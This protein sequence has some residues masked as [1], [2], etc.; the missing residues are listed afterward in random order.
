MFKRADYCIINRTFYPQ[1]KTIGEGLLILSEKLS[2]ENMKVIMIS[3]SRNLKKHLK[4]DERGDRVIFRP[5]FK[6]DTSSSTIFTR[7]LSSVFFGLWV[8]V[9]LTWY[10]PRKLYVS[11]DPPIVIPFI[12]ALSSKLFSISYVYHYQDIHPEITN[13]IK[14]LPNFIFNT[15]KKLD[16]F[17]QRNATKLITINSQMRNYLECRSQ[18]DQQIVCISNP[19]NPGID[20]P[21][22]ERIKGIVFCGNAGR[23]QRIPLV[24]LA[25]QEYLNRGGKLEFCF[26]GDGL[27]SNELKQLASENKKVSYYGY[28]DSNLCNEYIS[29]YMW[30]LLPLEE[31]ILDYAFPSKSSTY[32]SCNCKI[33]S[34]SSKGSSLEEWVKQN[35]NGINTEPFLEKVIESLFIIEDDCFRLYGDHKTKYIGD[36]STK[37]FAMQIKEVL[38]SNY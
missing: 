25:V 14:V 30:A 20:I 27:Y 13:K 16:I 10:R 2:E 15:L 24:I 3:S 19:S 18:A 26:I 23:L 8:F 5:L 29:S 38:N 35:S 11:T 21:F 22:N 4:A 34:I 33:L 1:N 37:N 32:L 28:L 12:V 31:G 9:N 17:S 7:I 36:F 6:F